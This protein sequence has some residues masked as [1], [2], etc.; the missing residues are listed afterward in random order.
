MGKQSE[1]ESG[2]AKPITG[3]R[4]KKTEFEFCKVCNINHDQG[5][6]HKYFPNHKKSLSAFLSRFQNK[7]CD[8]RFFLNTPSPLRSQL[9]SRNRL[10][11][12]F[13]DQD[14]QELS[15]SFACANVI[16]HLASV[17]HVK[18][19]KHFFWKYG[20]AMDQLDTF[21]VSDD[22]LAKWE[23]RCMALKPEPVVSSG[24]CC[25]AVFG[26]S[27][28]IHN[29]LNNGNI[30]SF[31][32]V[33]SHSLKSYPST[34]VLPLQCYTNEYQVS[35]SGQSGVSNTG[36]LDIDTSSLPSEACSGT[37]PFA[38]QDFAVE[39]SHSLPCNERQWSGDGYSFN[40]GVRDN[41]RMVSQV[42]SHKGPQMLS[43]ISS[44]P[45]GN[46]GGNVHSGAPPPWFEATEGVQIYS[47]PVS[48]DLVSHSN[49]SEKSKK[50]NPKRVGAAWAEKRKIE[51]E[52]ETRGETV[53]NEFDANW[54]PNFGRVWQSGSRKESRKEFEREKR[55]L[56]NVET[57]SEMPIKIQ[58]YVSKRM[59]MDSCGDYASG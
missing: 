13:C 38:L 26:T 58:P 17:E 8:A 47:E 27:S 22:D 34:G 39:R 10:W 52:M 40:K 55:K 21:K 29:Q 51:M 4:K 50:L 56:V 54:L 25:R 42:S 15:S 18:N 43:R 49:K 16:R 5:L 35:C 48:V 44:L 31:D 2:R 9:S 12:V 45:T 30:D 33:Y 53:R 11:C 32:N 23:K 14:I 24:Q 7:L 19:L 46:A 1:I 20:G 3:T 59:R 28:D 41:G 36:L 57:Q 37:N 6:R